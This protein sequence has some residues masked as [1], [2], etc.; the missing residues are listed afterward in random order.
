MPVIRPKA[1]LYID[2][3]ALSSSQQHV[4][5]MAVDSWYRQTKGCVQ[6][7]YGPRGVPVLRMNPVT[8]YDSDNTYDLGMYTP[9]GTDVK[10]LG[11]KGPAIELAFGRFQDVDTAVIVAAHEL[12]H[13]IGLPHVLD[14]SALMAWRINASHLSLSKSDREALANYT[15]CNLLVPPEN[16]P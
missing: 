7:V 4:V 3:S 13:A 12:G 8:K 11:F 10:D 9:F 14:L 15:A 2:I 5:E 6:F 1:V 16:T